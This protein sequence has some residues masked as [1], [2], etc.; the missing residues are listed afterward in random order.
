MRRRRYV[1][2][3]L[4]ASMTGW[5]VTL[6]CIALVCEVCARRALPARRWS[7]IRWTCSEH[8][9][10]RNIMMKAWRSETPKPEGGAATR[11]VCRAVAVVASSSFDVGVAGF[12]VTVCGLPS[13][14]LALAVSHSPVADRPALRWIE[15]SAQRGRG[16]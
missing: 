8:P 10:A 7:I 12:G 13:G 16:F 2:V 3:V 1:V 14:P 4:C 11:R 5:R 15:R 6:R 9:L